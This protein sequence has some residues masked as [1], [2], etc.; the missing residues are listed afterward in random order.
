MSEILNVLDINNYGLQSMIAGS[1]GEEDLTIEL[2]AQDTALST[3][4]NIIDQLESTLDNKIALDLQA[5][6]SDA[7]ATANDIAKDKTAYVNGVKLT[8]TASGSSTIVLPAG[9]LFYNS[10][11][12]SNFDWLENADTSLYTDMRDMFNSCRAVSTIPALNTDNV[13]LMSS[14]FSG[15]LHL[16]SFSLSDTSKVTDMSSMFYS[17]SSLI[18]LPV[19]NTSSVTNMQSMFGSRFGGNC[20]NLSSQSLNNIL[21]MCIN[22]T[23]YNSTKTLKDIGLTQTQATTCQTLSNW[24]A[25]V[26]AGWSTGY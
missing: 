7:N 26:A 15:C 25:F 20:D 19:L 8:G 3:Q 23:K 4:Q 10:Q 21:A 2:A 9:T 13:T 18:N 12:A 14:M 24:N 11:Q 22:A 6:T 16:T 17:C 5:A 1:G